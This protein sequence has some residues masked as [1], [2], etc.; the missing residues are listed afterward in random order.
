MDDDR[1]RWRPEQPT[2]YDGS[3]N[4]NKF[5]RFAQ[6]SRAYIDGYQM[7]PG[8]VPTA[9]SH[10]LDGRAWDYYAHVLTQ[11]M[12]NTVPTLKDILVGL[13]DYCFPLDIK[14]KI[15]TKARYF[16][17]GGRDVRKYINELET[18]LDLAGIH[19]DRDRLNQLWDGFR[20]EFRVG[21]LRAHV[22]PATHTWDEI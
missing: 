22:M 1:P 17:Q 19:E 5:Y 2:R 4:I 8:Q 11:K 9:I 10:F 18:L 21:L 12:Q 6:E 3:A 14:D 20:P 13:F 7:S 16:R 15:R